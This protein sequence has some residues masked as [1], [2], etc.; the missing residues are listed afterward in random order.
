MA[1]QTYYEILGLRR[2]ADP[3]VIRTAYRSLARRY[4]PDQNPGDPSAEE[5]FKAVA[6]AYRVLS[7]PESRHAYDSFGIVPPGAAYASL[8]VRPKRGVLDLVREV[9]KAAARA[10][11]RGDDIRLDVGL[12]FADA[13]R[14]SHRVL[15][16]PRR[17]K[18]GRIA[19]R[20]LRFDL[21]PNL[22]DGKVL[23]WPGEGAPEKGGGRS[24]DLYLTVAVTPHE[25]LRVDGADIICELPLALHELMAGT[26]VSVPTIHGPEVLTVPPN[27]W[28]GDKLRISAKGVTGGRIGDAVFHLSLLRPRSGPD[29]EE[30]AA[31]LYAGQPRSPRFVRCLVESAGWRDEE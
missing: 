9:A 8:Q 22:M 30:L 5:A 28:I 29:F 4:H 19:A 16:L 14:G 11:R 15:E 24:G 25:L 27:S 2:G 1:S 18:A 23:R 31:Q 17:N 26:A 10:I 21:P 20:R 7:D 6:E 12:S 13:V 3:D